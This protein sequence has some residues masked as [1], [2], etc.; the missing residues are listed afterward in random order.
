M[1]YTQLL[2]ASF[3]AAYKGKIEEE[4]GNVSLFMVDLTRLDLSGYNFKLCGKGH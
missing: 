3:G 2:S 1:T 4:L